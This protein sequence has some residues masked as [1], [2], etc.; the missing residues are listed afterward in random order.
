MLVEERRTEECRGSGHHGGSV[1]SPTAR[2]VFISYEAF[3]FLAS[4]FDFLAVIIPLLRMAIHIPEFYSK[5][6]GSHPHTHPIISSYTPFL[7]LSR[8]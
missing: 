8:L 6:G 3:C 5:K 1:V 7:S 4:S 2:G